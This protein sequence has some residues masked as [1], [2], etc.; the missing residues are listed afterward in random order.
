MATGKTGPT[1]PLQLGYRNASHQPGPLT[2]LREV[3]RLGYQSSAR[4]VPPASLNLAVLGDQDISELNRR[5]LGHPYPTD[6]LAFPDGEIDRQGRCYLGDIAL[7]ADCLARSAQERGIPY[8]L[9]FVFCAL[10]GLFHL[11]GMEDGD[12]AKR[13]AMYRRQLET[14]RRAG[15]DTTGLVKPEETR[16]KRTKGE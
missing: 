1:A 13:A 8:R 3:L 5:H 14:L 10:H 4:R 9:E 15:L 12:P 2:L 7:G 11:L 6:V 16:R